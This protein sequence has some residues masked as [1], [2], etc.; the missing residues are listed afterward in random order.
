MV[1][2][3]RQP[4]T[5]LAETPEIYG[6]EDLLL[7]RAVNAQVRDSLRERLQWWEEYTATAGGSMDNNPSPGNKSGGITTI[8]EKSLGAVAKSGTAALK[9]VYQ[10]AE[11]ITARGLSFMDTP[12]YDPVSVTGLVA[13]GCTLIAFTTGRGSAIGTR[14]APTI[15][16]ATSWMSLRARRLGAK[17]SA[18][19]RTSSCPGISEQ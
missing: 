8:L 16:I 10:F 19:G 6:A 12:G 11:P 15:K 9:A 7:S 1:V 13:G 3:H 5:I 17:Y 14:P 2:H 4:R 18:T